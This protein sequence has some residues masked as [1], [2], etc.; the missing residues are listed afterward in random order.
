[1]GKPPLGGR[2]KTRLS[3]D[4]GVGPAAMFYRQSAARVLR[5]LGGDSRWH[6]KL[7]VNAAPTEHYDCWPRHLKRISQGTGSLGERMAFAMAQ[8]P[9]GPVVVIG[10]DSPQVEPGQIAAAFKA[11]G[12][13]EAVFGPAND[14]GYW[15][16]GIN[17]RRPSPY[18]FS[19]VRWSTEHALADTV[20]SLP[21]TFSVG[22]LDTIIDVDTGD[23][24]RALRSAHGPLRLGPWVMATG[25]SSS[26]SGP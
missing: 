11:L 9:K 26:S 6:L 17:R 20:D 4:I 8:A 12:Q 10:T 3:Q 23:D 2:V 14:G 21:P 22:H 16:I 15:L 18:L 13:H 25:P 1:M 7:A 19:N 5:R 24:L